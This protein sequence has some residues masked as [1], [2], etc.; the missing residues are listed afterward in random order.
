MVFLMVLI[1][2][3]FGCIGDENLNT[4]Y[5]NSNFSDTSAFTPVIRKY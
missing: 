5:F 1:S 4:N 2:A 3:P